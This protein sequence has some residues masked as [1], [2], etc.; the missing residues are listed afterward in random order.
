MTTLGELRERYGPCHEGTDI[1]KGP[2]KYQGEMLYV[3]FLWEG[4]SAD[5]EEY[6]DGVDY[7]IYFVDDRPEGFPPDELLTLSLDDLSAGEAVVLYER[8]DGFVC[9]LSGGLATLADLRRA[10]GEKEEAQEEDA[11]EARRDRDD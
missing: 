11:D 2:G 5:R 9:E 3:P 7:Y 8:D 1:I 10:E 6:I 4:D